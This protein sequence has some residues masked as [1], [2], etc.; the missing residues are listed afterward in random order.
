M[1]NFPSSMRNPPMETKGLTTLETFMDTLPDVKTTCI[2]L[3][4]LWTLSR[5]PDD[6]VP[7]GLGVR[8]LR[9]QA[10]AGRPTTGE[11]CQGCRVL[12]P[13]RPLGHFPDIHFVEEAPR[14]SIEAFRQRLAQISHNIRQRNKCLPIP[15]YYL[16]PVLVENSISI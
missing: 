16:D 15:Y 7:W 4:V 1:P 3:L 9:A 14:R 12:R 6:K 2:T 11:G 10:G 8:E 13:Q 5:E